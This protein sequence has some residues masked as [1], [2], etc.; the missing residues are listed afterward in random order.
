MFHKHTKRALKAA[1]RPT[2][3]LSHYGTRHAIYKTLHFCI[4][5]IQR[6]RSHYSYFSSLIRTTSSPSNNLQQRNYCSD[7][8]IANID[9][10]TY[11][12]SISLYSEPFRFT[13]IRYSTWHPQ[14]Q[15]MLYQWRSD[16]LNNRDV[17]NSLWGRGAGAGARGRR[18]SGGGRREG[19]PHPAMGVRGFSP[20]KILK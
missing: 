4:I 16:V 8:Y 1:I 10:H 14:S 9:I 19:S 20:V 12:M 3:L 6:R 5:K 17:Q 11:S 2:P 13:H 15:A 7:T 18:P